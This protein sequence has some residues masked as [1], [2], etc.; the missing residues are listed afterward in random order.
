MYRPKLLRSVAAALVLS[1][2]AAHA[3]ADPVKVTEG[4]IQVGVAGSDFVFRTAADVEYSGERETGLFPT[5][6]SGMSGDVVNLSSTF[7]DRVSLLIFG[8]DRMDVAARAHFEF[9]AGDA[10]VP[11][12]DEV[13]ASP[14]GLHVFAPFAFTGN[15][16]LFASFQDALSNVNPIAQHDLFGTGRAQSLFRVQM[17]NTGE[18][19]PELPLVSSSVVYRFGE[20]ADSAPV[21]EPG[22]MLLLLGGMAA[23]AARA[24]RGRRHAPR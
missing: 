2:L 16:T 23:T 5:M 15:F 24:R 1:G 8:P 18:F 4:Y 10:V 13:L 22:T 6:L 7:D 21:P 20:V 17:T 9:T 12:V 11:P 3:S 14:N 19:L